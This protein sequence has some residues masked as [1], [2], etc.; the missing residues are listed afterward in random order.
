MHDEK[1]KELLQIG[2]L[3]QKEIDLSILA[4][5]YK[6]DSTEAKMIQAMTKAIFWLGQKEA[7]KFTQMIY[8]GKISTVQAQRVF[9]DIS[10]KATK[11][12]EEMK[13]RNE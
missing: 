7:L 11:E 13:K 12:L 3:Y 4:L 2:E 8:E 5:G 9:E 6:L 10:A 1:L